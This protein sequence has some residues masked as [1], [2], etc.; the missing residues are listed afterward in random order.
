MVKKATDEVTQREA[1]LLIQVRT[2]ALNNDLHS[3]L[4]RWCAEDGNVSGAVNGAAPL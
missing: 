3:T 1:H 4:G 2:Q